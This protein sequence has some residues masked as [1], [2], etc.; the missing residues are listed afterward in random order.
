GSSGVL[1]PAPKLAQNEQQVDLRKRLCKPIACQRPP[2]A[3][4]LKVVRQPPRRLSQRSRGSATGGGGGGDRGGDGCSGSATS[5]GSSGESSNPNKSL[6][7]GA[8]TSGSGAAAGVSTVS[9]ISTLKVMTATSLAPPSPPTARSR[10]APFPNGG[11]GGGGDDSGFPK[12][13][14]SLSSRDS[15]GDEGTEDYYAAVRRM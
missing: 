5:L 1:Q 2:T 6:T 7:G 14:V 3:T 15:S 13:R 10:L 9:S 8:A 4:E 12:K 11:G